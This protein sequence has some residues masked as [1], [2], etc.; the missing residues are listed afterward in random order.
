MKRRTP[1]DRGPRV[2]RVAA[3]GAIAVAMLP[4]VFPATARAAKLQKRYYAHTAVHDKY[5]VIAPWYTAQN[6]QLDFRVRIAAETLKRYPWTDTK[7]A[8]AAVPHY[9]FNG[10]WKIAPDGAITPVPINDWDNGD[11]GQRAAY[12]L[13]GLVDYY[14]YTGDASAIGLMTLQADALLDYGLTPPDH[15]WPKFLISVPTKGKPYGQ[16]NPQGM[17]QLDIVAEAGLGLLKAYQ[18]TGNQRWFEACKHW[19][20]LFAK[21]CNKGAGGTASSSGSEASAAPTRADK[22]PV[23]PAPWGRYAN[24]ESA[25][26]KDNKQTGGGGFILYFLD[27]LIR[28]G[29]TGKDNAIVQARDAGRV[30]LRDVLLPAWTVNDTWGRNYWDWADPVQAENVTE[31]AARYMMDNKEYFPNWKNDVR[32]ILSLFINHTSVCPNSAGEVYSGAWAFPESAGCCGR[33]LW[34]G[35]MEMVVPFAQ[36]GV[37]AKSEWAREIARRMQI[38]ATYD[39]H[40]TGVSEDNIDGGFVVNNAWFK[41]AHPMALRHLLGTIAWMPEVFAPAGENHIV[42]STAVVSNTDYGHGIVR[43]TTFDAPRGTFTTLRT[44]FEPEA[45]NIVIECK[46]RKLSRKDLTQNGYRVKALSGGDFL[47]T[48]RHDGARE[49]VV[50]GDEI[51]PNSVAFFY[52]AEIPES[53]RHAGTVIASE[54]PWSARPLLAR[55]AEHAGASATVKFRGNRVRVNGNVGPDGG[56]AEVYVDGVKQVVGIDCWNPAPRTLQTLYY[57]NGLADGDHTLK[58][59]VQGKRNPRSSGSKVYLNLVE[60]CGA[61]GAPGFGEGGGPTDTQRM[62]LGYPGREDIKDSAGNLWRPCTEFV[63]RSGTMKDSVAESWWTAP[64]RSPA[65]GTKD[66][67]LYRYGVHAKEFI[68]NVTVGPGT[69]YARLKF[70]ATR[71]RDT[72]QHC[73]TIA[74]NGQEVVRKMDVAAT[75]GGPN[76]A[77]DLV[78]NNISPRNGVIDIRFTGGDPAQG[79]DGEAFCQA[80]EVGPGDGGTGAKPVTVA[81]RNLLRNGGFEQWYHSTTPGL[82][83]AV[84]WRFE[85]ASPVETPGMIDE[86]HVSVGRVVGGAAEVTEGQQAARVF[87]KGRSRLFQEVGARPNTVYRG[88]VFVRARDLGGQGFGRRGDDSAGLVLEELDGSG[89]VVATHPKAAISQAGPY[90]YLSTEVTTKAE[91]ARLRFVLDTVLG[92][93]AKHGSVTYD[94]CVLDGPAAPAFITGRVTTQGN[95][96]IEGAL[97]AVQVPPGVSVTA[98]PQTVRSGPDGT[99]K[100]GGLSDLMRCVVVA[101]KQG[102]YPDLKPLFLEAGENR[103]ELVLPALPTNNLLVNGDFEQGFAAARSVEHGASGVRGPWS[104]EFS[105]GVACYIYPESVYDWRKPRILRGKEAVSHVTDGGGRLRLWQ[106]VVVDPNTALVASVWVQGLDVQGDGKGFGAGAKDFAGLRIEELDAQGN[107][108]LS[109]EEAGLRKATPDFQRV[110]CAFTTGAK[111]AKVRFAL[112][113]VIE[114]IWRQGAA[115]YDD[116]ALEKAPSKK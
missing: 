75:A 78:F 11:L 37:E 36:Y 95:T 2:L 44:A 1:T 22:P 88:A 7:T 63:V 24:P 93:E 50:L 61:K 49:V 94:Q 15:P 14:R 42:N 96:P 27:E 87:G 80:I 107:V 68:V 43:F 30:Y 104:F 64:C 51:E 110:S 25:P 62:V 17:I 58:L 103:C 13:L 102:C 28:L 85:H 65:D 73:V 99:F 105:P 71:G 26:W 111:T 82:A 55:V 20:D 19:G 60:W 18:V 67:D 115:I 109:H 59:A 92:G 9:V 52:G 57:R 97:V 45:L 5:G 72:C 12:V 16:S 21:H 77:V 41:I 114:C 106:D 91:T 6:G 48:V 74:L 84:D 100:I 38:L 108:L 47:V 10:H 23:P 66:P 8:A 90:R 40:E 46:A 39:G 101:Q 83:A 69:Y 34:Y 31:F 32:N 54:G 89:K 86:L 53:L 98:K 116:C 113:S 112:V 4:A 79:I 35:P 76:R 81:H 56:L 70:A 3:L 33:S 29:Y